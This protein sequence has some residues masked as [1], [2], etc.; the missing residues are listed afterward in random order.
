MSNVSLYIDPPS[1]HFLN[2]R[3]FASSL[4]ANH[5]SMSRC[6]VLLRDHLTAAGIAVHTADRL[7]IDRGGGTKIYVSFGM[8]QDFKR[9]ADRGDVQLSAI[10]VTEAP[11]VEPL[12][13]R[14]V[15]EVRRR[16]KRIYS[17]CNDPALER[18]FGT[19]LEVEPIRWP[20]DRSQVDEPLW[21]RKDR[22][23]LVMINMNKLPAVYW[24]ELYTERMRAVEYFARRGEIDL[25]GVGWDRASMRLG[26]TWIPGTLRRAHHELRCLWDRV[27][28]DPLLVAARTAYKGQLETKFETL[29][30]YDFALCF[31]NVPLKGWVTEKIF[32]CFFV[33][34]IPIYLG[35]TDI[36]DLVPAECFID[37]RRFETYDELARHL[38]SLGE[39]DILRY[40]QN[41][42]DFVESSKFHPFSKDAF[43]S[44]FERIIEEDGGVGVP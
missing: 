12:L 18:F 22:G 40:R 6:F 17:C 31:E 43:I 42:R 14:R 15:A 1:H 21:R 13:Y 25:Y 26:A 16:F 37:M 35:A 23:F 34:T 41:A 19:K 8:L 20:M 10:F 33:G 39:Q 2:D 5:S 27:Y 36:E 24:K 4:G 29:A 32:E 7:R 11:I 30:S 28:P 9:I 3:L 44:R 38:K